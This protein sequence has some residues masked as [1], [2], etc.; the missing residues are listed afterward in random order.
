LGVTRVELQL[1]KAAISFTELNGDDA[2]T[3]IKDEAFDEV[4]LGL[5]LKNARHGGKEGEACAS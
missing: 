5:R 2:A 4:G 3:S 1:T